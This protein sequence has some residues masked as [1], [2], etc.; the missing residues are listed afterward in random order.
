MFFKK[1]IEAIKE[2]DSPP[3]FFKKIHIID[4]NPAGGT[5]KKRIVY[6]PD[7]T[8]RLIHKTLINYLRRLSV[9]LSFA[10][11]GVKLKSLIKHILVH[12]GKRYIYLI[13]IKSAYLNVDAKKL[14]RVISDLDDGVKE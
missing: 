11:G 5:K 6:K 1:K 4:V 3:G 12:A 13:D 10:F 8:M 14:A 9:D 2:S 7:Y